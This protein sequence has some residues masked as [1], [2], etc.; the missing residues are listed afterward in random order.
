MDVSALRGEALADYLHYNLTALHQ[1][2]SELG[3]EFGW[4]PWDTSRGW[5]DKTVVDEGVDV[6]MFLG[7]IM[8]ACGVTDRQFRRALKK[9]RN[10]VRRRQRT[11]TYTKRKS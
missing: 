5:V 4:A 7:N 2:V 10:I 9:K 3:N 6:A 8:A 11:G 1:E